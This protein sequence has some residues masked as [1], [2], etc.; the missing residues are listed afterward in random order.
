MTFFILLIPYTA[1]PQQEGFELCGSTYIQIFIDIDTY[2][3]RYYIY[4]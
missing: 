4:I 2:V 3:S 1:D